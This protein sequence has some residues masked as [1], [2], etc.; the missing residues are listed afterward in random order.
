MCRTK[1]QDRPRPFSAEAGGSKTEEH[2]LR[3]HCGGRGSRRCTH[4][5]RGQPSPSANQSARQCASGSTERGPDEGSPSSTFRMPIG[6]GV[7]K[8][9]L[10]GTM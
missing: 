8:L 5:D 7:G 10:G 4:R 1:T 2:G 3:G 6:K 9:V